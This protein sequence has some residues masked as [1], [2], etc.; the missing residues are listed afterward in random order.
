MQTKSQL[1][2]MG[3]D[4][5]KTA[6]MSRLFFSRFS[7]IA[8]LLVFL[9]GASLGAHGAFRWPESIGIVLILAWAIL[10][11]GRVAWEFWR[12]S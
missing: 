7:L 6:P 11:T 9:A 2:L 5:A 1:A 8:L 12:G 3:E 10:V 4:K